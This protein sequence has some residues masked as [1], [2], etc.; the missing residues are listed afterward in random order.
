MLY[1]TKKVPFV[2]KEDNMKNR[3]VVILLEAFEVNTHHEKY[4]KKRYILACDTFFYFF[5][6][7]M[8]Y[9]I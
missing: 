1:I 8:S 5:Y 7:K 4:F 2:N 3:G 9:T 6:W